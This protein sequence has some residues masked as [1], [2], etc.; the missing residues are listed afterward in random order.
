MK[1]GLKMTG[2]F[3]LMAVGMLVLGACPQEAEGTQYTVTFDP[4]GGTVEPTTIQVESGKTISVLP[5]PTKSGSSFGGWYTGANGT[6]NQFTTSTA[7]TGNI[8]VYAKW[9]DTDF[10]PKADGK[11][12][13]TNNSGE[14]LA[15]FYDSVM[16]SH[17]LGGLPANASAHKI[18]LPDSGTF[19]VIHAIKYSDYQGKPASEI[20]NL[21]VVD[22]AFTYSDSQNDTSCE[23]GNPGFG[24]NAEIQFQ[25]QTPKNWIE[26]GKDG[27]GP[28]DRFFVM[29]PQSNG[30]VYVNPLSGGYHLY[31]T[32]YL[33]MMK[34]GQIIGVQRSFFDADLY[35]PQP[36]QPTIISISTTGQN[37]IIPYYREGYIRVLNNSSRGY[38]MTN[39]STT[40]MSTLQVS[41]VASGKEQ[42]FELLGASGEGQNYQQLK[43]LA[44]MAEYNKD[45]PAF[46]VKNGYA[47][48]IEIDSDFVIH[49]SDG[50]ELDPEE[51][52]IPW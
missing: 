3:L 33:R 10:T 16:A 4:A 5:T 39:G 13:V 11:L 52:E 48:T 20:A 44:V 17:F 51:E 50:I 19:Y 21:K 25:N 18:K 47:Y 28:E 36:G 12:L 27:T 37:A 23:L 15:L 35:D 14:N 8:T 34:S 1:K 6:G 45:I 30:T 40:L 9:N 46:K 24:G 49:I 26:V 22:S 41:A 43:L 42:V 2:W 7:V 38:T 29:K 32:V 31:F